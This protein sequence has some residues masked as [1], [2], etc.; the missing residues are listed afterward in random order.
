M[1][2]DMVEC[3]QESKHMRDAS[4]YYQAMHDLVTCAPDVESI[5][6]PLLRNLLMVSSSTLSGRIA[7]AYTHRI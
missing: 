7:V 1:T 3:S 2:M 5:G 6:V 4:T